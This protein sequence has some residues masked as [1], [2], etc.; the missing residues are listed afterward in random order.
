MEVDRAVSPQAV[1]G[2][3]R[4]EIEKAP[5]THSFIHPFIYLSSSS[6]FTHPI[7]LPN[8]YIHAFIHPPS[9][10]SSQE[11]VYRG[12]KCQAKE[13]GNSLEVI[14]GHGSLVVWEEPP[15]CC[16]EDVS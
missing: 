2:F 8:P 12:L 13:F 10:L 14:G 6:P 16:V 15:G 9:P 7:H 1:P 4:R 5:L 3:S 11:H